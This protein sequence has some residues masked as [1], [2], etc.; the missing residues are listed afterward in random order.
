VWRLNGRSGQLVVDPEVDLSRVEFSL[1][2]ASWIV[3]LGANP[4][5]I[6]ALLTSEGDEALSRV[7]ELLSSLCEGLGMDVRG[8]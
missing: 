1:G 8:E 6:D 7:R 5:K 4:T 2:P 3:P